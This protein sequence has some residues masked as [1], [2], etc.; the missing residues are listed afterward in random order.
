MRLH[1]R[2]YRDGR[3]WLAEIPILDAMTQGRTR[4]EALL[5][6][7]DLVRTLA[8]RPSL[9][10]RVYP[11]G[12]DGFEVGALETRTLTSLMLRR[13]RERSGLSL[14]DVAE[15]LGAKSRNAYA[16]YERGTSAPT[17]EKLNELLRA[18][19]PDRDLVLDQ[20]E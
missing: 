11:T 9:T 1:G 6:V 14:A 16:R 15:R 12:Q 20:S 4:Q 5:M 13:Q 10:L 8:N 17:L 2:L 3:Y 19:S 18:V 7:E